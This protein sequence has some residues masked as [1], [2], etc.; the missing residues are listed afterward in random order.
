MLRSSDIPITEV[1][2]YFTNY[3]LDV[4]F[5]V[6]TE[7]GLKKSIMDATGTVR[8]FLKSNSIH[9]YAAQEPGGDRVYVPAYFC[10]AQGI[11]KHTA[12]LYRP[13]TK[14]GDPRI[15]FSRLGAFCRPHNLLGVVAIDD[16]LYVFNLS[17]PSTRLSIEQREGLLRNLLLD[18]AMSFDNTVGELLTKLTA[19]HKRGF[20]QSLSIGDP[21][22]GETLEML[23]GIKRNPSKEPD[24]KGIELKGKRGGVTGTPKTRSTI[25]SQVPNWE[26][27]RIKSYG[28]LVDTYGY[29]NNDGTRLDLNVTLKANTPNPQGL[30]LSVDEEADI[31]HNLH[32]NTSGTEIAKVVLWELDLLRERLRSKHRETFWVGAYVE[33]E[34]GTELF[35]Y[36]EVLHTH[37]PR[38]NLLGLLI[39]QS[40]ITLDY[41]AHREIDNGV[42][43]ACRNHGVLFKINPSDLHFL[44]P[45]PTAY[46]LA[47]FD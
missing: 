30:Y 38:T 5:L 9:D 40:I 34:G 6:P 16:S 39:D 3:G 10:D 20:V 4:A 35:H 13:K 43:R 23:L 12:S 18:A 42:M 32:R 28:E 2:H 27:S 17:D 26:K 31:L 8:E 41:L 19:I 11:Y 47:A 1:L 7:T 33:K 46:N 29:M 37:K 15:W 14:N 36:Y 25:F 22:V 45:E 44:F 24:Y 21:G